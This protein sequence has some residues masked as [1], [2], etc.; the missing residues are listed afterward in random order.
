MNCTTY[1]T[2]CAATIQASNEVNAENAI[3]IQPLADGSDLVLC[4]FGTAFTV[5]TQRKNADGSVTYRQ[6]AQVRG[7]AA[8]VRQAC[9][10]RDYLNAAAAAA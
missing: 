9:A 2:A 5:H 7:K 10:V 4:K 8:G 3:A 6:F 1:T